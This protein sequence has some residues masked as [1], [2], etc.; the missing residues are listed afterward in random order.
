MCL[1]SLGSF[2]QLG[3]SA[4]RATSRDR[5]F[6][7]YRWAS[8]RIPSPSL[9]ALHVASWAVGLMS[10]GDETLGTLTQFTFGR[11]RRFV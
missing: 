1:W 5:C 10:V 6:P 2:P 7:A 8:G 3:F 11:S 4:L 9:P